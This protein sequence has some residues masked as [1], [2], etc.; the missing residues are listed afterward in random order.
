MVRD[1]RPRKTGGIGTGQRT[2]QPIDEAGHIRFVSEYLSP[3]NASANNVV[4]ATRRVDAC[5]SRHLVL[6][7]QLRNNRKASLHPRPPITMIQYQEFGFV[8]DLVPVAEGVLQMEMQE[9]IIGSV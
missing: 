4:Q 6:L 1:Q 7:T 9:N 3:F 8:P 5:F 2:A